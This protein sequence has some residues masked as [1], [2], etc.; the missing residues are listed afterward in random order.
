MLPLI[1]AIVGVLVPL[2]VLLTRW[3]A[4][5]VCRYASR[6][7]GH[8]DMYLQVVSRGGLPLY[9]ARLC[10]HCGRLQKGEIDES[11]VDFALRMMQADQEEVARRY[12]HAVEEGR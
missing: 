6:L 8:D 9:P 3:P 11:A 7:P 4:A 12:G 2:F 5:I 10:I 1:M